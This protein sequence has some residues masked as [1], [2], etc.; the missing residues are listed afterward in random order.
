MTRRFGGCAGVAMAGISTSPLAPSRG[1]AWHLD[2]AP[3]SGGDGRLPQAR[4][5]VAQAEDGGRAASAVDAG[6]RR[7]VVGPYSHLTLAAVAVEQPR[8]PDVQ[9]RSADQPE[10][11]ADPDLALHDH[12]RVA[13]ALAPLQ[14]AV[15]GLLLRQAEPV[16]HQP[17]I[18]QTSS[19]RQSA[20]I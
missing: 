3:G 17:A 7:I 16:S 20:I 6:L 13:V 8:E 15:V 14:V 9:P 11:A 4:P 5:K 18:S 1:D 2:V 12:H 10:D 19:S